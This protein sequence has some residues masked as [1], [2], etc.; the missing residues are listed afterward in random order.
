[1]PA[2]IPEAA[3]RP[4]PHGASGAAAL[5]TCCAA[6]PGADVLLGGTLNDA[7]MFEDMGDSGPP[8]APAL[9]SEGAGMR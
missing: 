1:M 5:T 2:G 3:G 6:A 8:R 9:Q 7:G 4:P